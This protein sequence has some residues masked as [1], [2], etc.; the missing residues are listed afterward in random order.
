MVQ[1]MEKTTSGATKKLML[2]SFHVNEDLEK[3]EKHGIFTVYTLGGK[4][5][6]SANRL[7]T[8]YY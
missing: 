7:R 3:H 2:N 8:V 5:L 6:I 1:N 4:G